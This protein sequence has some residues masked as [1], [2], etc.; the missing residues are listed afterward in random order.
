[1]KT[2]NINST[3]SFFKQIEK[4]QK[5]SWWKFRGQANVEW[6]LLPKAGRKNL[7]NYNDHEM[8][9]SWKRRAKKLV[10]A[11][12][13][14]DWDYLAIA[15]HSGL[16]TRLLDWSHN[17][18]I[19]AFFACIDLMESDGVV[20]AYFGRDAIINKEDFSPFEINSIG[21]VVPDITNNR[22]ENQYGYFT[23]HN[24]PKVELTK[25]NC[26]GKLIK[27]V[28][29]KDIKKDMIFKLNHFGINYLHIYPDLE[30][31][32]KHLSWFSENYDY[33]TN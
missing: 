29:S 26:R 14:S 28:I 20:Y 10:E 8:F 11:S 17:P 4:F 7:S 22:I 15:Q 24:D 25:N 13:D 19:A 27:L 30:G 3:E 1:M 6:P 9:T 33:W 32:S 16:P 2:I 23:I 31:L 21:L 18:L 12:Y 5:D